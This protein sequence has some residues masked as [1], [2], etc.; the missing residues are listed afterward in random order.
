[1]STWNYRVVKTIPGEAA[2]LS[3]LSIFEVYYD[4]DGKIDGFS[5]KPQHAQGDDLNELVNDLKFMGDALNRP[6]L[7]RAWDCPDELQELI[8]S[9]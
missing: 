4:A 8:T 5:D 7:V 1:M 6:V 2:E 9:G 3:Y